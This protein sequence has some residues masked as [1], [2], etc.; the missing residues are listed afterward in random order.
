MWRATLKLLINH[1]I[2]DGPWGGGNSFVL[3]LTAYIQNNF[4][5]SIFLVDS[6]FEKPDV[7]FFTDYRPNNPRNK[8]NFLQAVW[9]RIFNNKCTFVYRCNENGARKN[10]YSDDIWIQCFIKACDRTIFISDYLKSYFARAASAGSFVIRNVVDPTALSFYRKRSLRKSGVSIVTHHWGSSLNKGWDVYLRLDAMCAD[11]GYSFTFIGNLPDGVVLRHSRVVAPTSGTH[12]YQLLSDHD[13]YITGSL[14]EPAG[15]HHIEGCAL[16]LPVVYRESGALPEYCR[17]YGVGFSDLEGVE[18]A[19]ESC[20]NAYDFYVKQLCDYQFSKTDEAYV[21]WVDALMAEAG[22]FKRAAR[23][24]ES[25]ARLVCTG[26]LI[27]YNVG[28]L[29]SVRF[30]GIGCRLKKYAR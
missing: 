24:I 16:G 6:V 8:I 22:G 15:M 5:D 26:V 19:L 14:H 18:S 9:Y 29:I 11:K 27:A 21:A 23:G 20:V 13:I 25:L 17:S 2:V 7:I 3:G 1:N 28:V 30:R 10:K 4:A 12:L